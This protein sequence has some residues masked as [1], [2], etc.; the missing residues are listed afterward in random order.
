MLHAADG[1]G[2]RRVLVTGEV[3]KTEQV[4]VAD[5]EEEMAGA[6]IVAVFHQLHQREAEELLVELDG[7]LDVLADQGEMVDTLDGGGRPLAAGAQVLLP[8]LVPPCPDL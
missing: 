6:R 4:V 2:E 1:L 3:E 7:L 8:Q 5:V